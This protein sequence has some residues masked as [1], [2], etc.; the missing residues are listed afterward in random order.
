[1]APVTE[2]FAPL[3]PLAAFTGNWI[4][5]GFN[6]IFRPNS[7]KTPTGPFPISPIGPDETVLELNLTSESLSFAASLGNIT[8]RGVDAQGDIV[9]NGV[10]YLQVINDVTTL[11]SRGIHFEPG[12]WLSI[13]A[14]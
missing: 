2:I 1:M 5:S 11:P 12:I 4:G 10:P 6:T 14:T 3:G 13:P 7:K 8:N 9:L